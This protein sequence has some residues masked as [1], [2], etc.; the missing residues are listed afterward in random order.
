MPASSW[1]SQR[2][3]QIRTS[4]QRTGDA[5]EEQALRYLEKQGLHLVQRSFL[6]KGGEIDLIMQEGA[7]LVFVEVRCRSSASFGGAAASI[8]ASKQK[9]WQHA[10]QV[11]LQQLSH[12]PECRFDVIAFEQ[13]QLSW[14]K[15]V[16]CNY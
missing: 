7:C 13:G 3:S 15:N 14:L 4:R 6:C 16:V 2:L 8:T 10:A 11:Y 5:A 12:T 1:L 9:R